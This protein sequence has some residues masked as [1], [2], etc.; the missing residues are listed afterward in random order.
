MTTAAAVLS[1]GPCTA[2]VIAAV[3]P[4]AAV[5]AATMLPAAA[6]AA[7]ASMAACSGATTAISRS[8]SCRDLAA[9]AAAVIRLRCVLVCGM[10]G[11]RDCGS[12]DSSLLG[13]RL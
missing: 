12:V 1:A 8:E 11:R 2:A 7:A 4:V 3:L 9:G 5:E 13:L 10:C 6:R